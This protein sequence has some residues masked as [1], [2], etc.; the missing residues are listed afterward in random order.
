MKNNVLYVVAV[1]VVVYDVVDFVVVLWSVCWKQS[2]DVTGLTE[3]VSCAD[4]AHTLPMQKHGRHQS[5]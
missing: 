1:Y 2:Y 5:V 3:P 4:T